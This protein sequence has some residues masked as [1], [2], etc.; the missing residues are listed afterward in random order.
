MA[1]KT[2]RKPKT[3]K[4]PKISP[5]TAAPPT[6]NDDMV[7]AVGMGTWTKAAT[8]QDAISMLWRAVQGQMTPSQFEVSTYRV[9]EETHI[10]GMGQFVRP[11]TDDPPRLIRQF[12]LVNETGEIVE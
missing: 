2:T 8:E 3:T 10:G 1:I 12:S 7:I 11:T 9:S 4:E 6:S 5:K